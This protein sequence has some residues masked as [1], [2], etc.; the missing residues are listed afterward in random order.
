[1]GNV[2]QRYPAVDDRIA[3]TGLHLFTV[4][5]T[6][7]ASCISAFPGYS[8]GGEPAAH[9]ENVKLPSPL[10]MW[11]IRY[12]FIASLSSSTRVLEEGVLLW[13]G[14]DDLL[15][16]TEY[17]SEEWLEYP[18]DEL[19]VWEISIIV[20]NLWTALFDALTRKSIANIKL[21]ESREGQS[22]KRMQ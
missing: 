12:Y 9:L 21:A 16:C 17:P 19:W 11:A 10:E 22:R 1:M 20:G 3:P 13:F 4:V 8:V 6:G 7:K 2:I 18:V 14:E 15:C 5:E